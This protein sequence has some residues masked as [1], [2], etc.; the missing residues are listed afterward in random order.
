[1]GIRLSC[2]CLRGRTLTSHANEASGEVPAPNL[3]CLNG[4]VFARTQSM[5]TSPRGTEPVGWRANFLP[6]IRFRR[7]R[8]QGPVWVTEAL[9]PHYLVCPVQLAHSRPPRPGTLP[10]SVM[11]S[12]LEVVGRLSL[13]RDA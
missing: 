4:I 6:R 10:V 5:N 11:S 1:V 3:P 8:R 2:R 9:F 12:T 7:T 13:T